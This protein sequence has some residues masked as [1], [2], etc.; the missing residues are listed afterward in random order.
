V[1][2]DLPMNHVLRELAR[3][4]DSWEELSPGIRMHPLYGFEGEGS[5]A[6]LLS[7]SPG[8]TLAR[9]AH[10]GFE[11]ILILE[12]EQRDE[13]GAYGEGTLVINPP[14]T[15]HHVSSPKGCLVLAI[16]EKPVVF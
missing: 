8:A 2:N 16:W 6:A 14:G 3:S 10:P 11:H 15:N 5:R 4:R 1:P 7:Y 13:R 9:H 12:G